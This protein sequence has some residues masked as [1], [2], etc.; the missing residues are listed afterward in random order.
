MGPHNS[1]GPLDWSRSSSLSEER[2]RY[3]SRPDPDD[4]DHRHQLK[5]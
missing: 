3:D 4:Y 1:D 2:G 5:E